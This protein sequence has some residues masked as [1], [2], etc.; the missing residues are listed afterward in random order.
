MKIHPVRDLVIY[1]GMFRLSFSRKFPGLVFMS[2]APLRSRAWR[3]STLFIGWRARGRTLRAA[4]KAASMGRS[5]ASMGIQAS[6]RGMR[7]AG[8]GSGRSLA[9]T[10]R[11]VADVVLVPG[12]AV[13][14]DPYD[15]SGGAGRGGSPARGLAERAHGGVNGRRSGLGL[16][17]LPRPSGCGPGTHESAH[18]KQA[19]PITGGEGPVPTV[20]PRLAGI[21]GDCAGSCIGHHRATAG[22]VSG[23]QHRRKRAPGPEVPA[24]RGA[25]WSGWRV[26]GSPRRRRRPSRRRG[27]RPVGGLPCPWSP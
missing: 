14:A 12:T 20:D 15:A 9:G 17:R 2:W 25:W 19:R 6:M 13:L 18:V 16:R 11:P 24:G 4:R 27:R 5:R 8:P 1:S 7:P 26:S 22:L 23:C 3:R 21:D 10:G